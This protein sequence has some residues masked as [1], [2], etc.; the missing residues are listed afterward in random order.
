MNKNAYE[1]V[2]APN[3]MKLLVVPTKKKS[4]GKPLKKAEEFHAKRQEYR[5]TK[6]REYYL[7]V[8]ERYEQSLA[9]KGQSEAAPAAEP[10]TDA[11]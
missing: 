4:L 1:Q 7:R 6:A 10:S 9:R 8:R 11:A 2:I 3:G 5:E